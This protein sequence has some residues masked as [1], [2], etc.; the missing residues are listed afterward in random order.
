MDTVFNAFPNAIITDR[1]SIGELQR[2]TVTG[3]VYTEYG[4]LDVI[5]DEAQSS[6]I[7]RSPN[8]ETITA[9][10]LIYA[11]P[12][13]LPTTNPRALASSYMIYDSENDDYF[14]IIDA[15]LGKNQ[16]TGVLE[17]VQLLVKQTGVV[18]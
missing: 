6:T 4:V 12:D 5:V 3:N 14:Q 17:H 8:A 2:G 13:Q 11:I 18:S 15:S 7:D 10:M 16:E 1:F 9:D